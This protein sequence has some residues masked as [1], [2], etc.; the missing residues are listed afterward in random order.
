MLRF[1]LC[2][3]YLLESLQILAKMKMLMHN[4]AEEVE[5]A[6]LLV[7]RCMWWSYLLNVSMG[8]V[9]LIT[10]LFC[11]G[12]LDD[13]INSPAPYLSLFN[14]T[15]SVAVAMTLTIILLLLVFSGNVTALATTSREAWAFSRDRGFP[16]S[17]WISRVSLLRKV[18][19]CTD[20][21]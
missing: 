5:D 4:T 9:I 14:N 21:I 2:R 18:Q 10:M 13:A 17:R 12:D 8:I 15:G 7:P 3:T 20:M 1:R 6:S 19:R 11:I 16:F